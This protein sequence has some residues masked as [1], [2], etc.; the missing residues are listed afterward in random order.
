MKSK[1]S[2]PQEHRDA[3]DEISDKLLAE[4]I[5]YA[6]CIFQEKSMGHSPKSMTVVLGEKTLVITLH[7][8][9]TPTEMILLQDVGSPAAM[10]HFYEQLFVD[11][12]ESLR[13]E[14]QRITGKQILG[15]TTGFEPITGAVVQAFTT[16]DAATFFR[17][18]P[19]LSSTG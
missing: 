17:M 12:A 5:A 9:L 13:R 18:P 8:A 16:G 15:R 11:S 6:V 14:I 1:V 3:C 2:L 7:E 19:D 10:Q 4:Q